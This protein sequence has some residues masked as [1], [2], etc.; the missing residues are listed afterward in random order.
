MRHFAMPGTDGM[1]GRLTP[2]ITAELRAWH[3]WVRNS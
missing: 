1:P 2:A 3:L